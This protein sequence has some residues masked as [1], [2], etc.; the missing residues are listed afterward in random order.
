VSVLRCTD[1]TARPSAPSRP[2]PLVVGALIS[3]GP[4][5]PGP[6]DLALTHSPVRLIS[7]LV[8]HPRPARPAP[9]VVPTALA[10]S[11][12]CTTRQPARRLRRR[13]LVRG[14]S[15]LRLQTDGSL[16]TLR[17]PS[18]C[19][20]SSLRTPHFITRTEAIRGAANRVL[21]SQFYI[22]LYLSMALISCVLVPLCPSPLPRSADLVSLP[23]H[24]PQARDRRP[25]GHIRV[26][27]ARV[28]HPRDRRQLGHDPRG[29]D[30]VTRLWSGASPLPSSLRPRGRTLSCAR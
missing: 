19:A 30:P 28:L 16:L 25:V 21:F 22:F 29:R 20:H 5:R 24:P 8:Q 15:S 12:A 13:Q 6:L 7:P 2:A 17:P 27:D 11:D 3:L 1:S 10:L 4:A 18:P 26:P 9:H 23:P 14:Q